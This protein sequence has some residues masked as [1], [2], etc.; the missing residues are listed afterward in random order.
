MI[1]SAAL[2]IGTAIRTSRDRPR[3]VAN[4]CERKRNVERTHPEP[5]DPQSQTETLATHSG[6]TLTM[7]TKITMIT[8]S[9]PLTITMFVQTVNQNPDYYDYCGCFYG[10]HYPSPT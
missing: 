3:T 2:T 8:K 6:K 5:P 9:Q 7:I 4:G 1:P 10:N